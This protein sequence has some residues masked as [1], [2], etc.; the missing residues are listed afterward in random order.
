MQ[1][2]D[3]AVR[4]QPGRR[5]ALGQVIPDQVR[6]AFGCGQAAVAARSWLAGNQP[7]PRGRQPPGVGVSLVGGRRYFL[8]C[9]HCLAATSTA[10]PGR[11][12]C[13]DSPGVKAPASTLG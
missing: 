7:S 13:T 8:A 11:L 4:C 12:I 6:L 3:S 1:A 5:L 9:R 10:A 2:I